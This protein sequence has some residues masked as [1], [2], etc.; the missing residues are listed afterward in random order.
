MK[1]ILSILTFF[2]VGI[3]FTSGQDDA[4]WIRPNKGQWD[5]K[6]LYKVDLQKGH[7]FVEKDKFTYALTDYKEVSHA[8]H[9]ENSDTDLVKSHTV[10]SHFV[11]S[12]W[13]GQKVELNPSPFYENYFLGD[14]STKWKSKVFAFQH[15][16]LLDFYPGID[17]ILQSFPDKL[18]YSFRVAP[19][20][21]PSLIQVFHEGADEVEVT[22]DEVKIHTRFG[23]I[24]ENELLVWE[25][26]ENGTKTRV[27]SKFIKKGDTVSFKLD[28]YN[29][30][31]TLI[32]DPSLT[33][34]TFTGSPVD[35]WGFTAA[36]DDEGNLYG[37]GIVFGTGYPTTV[38]AYDVSFNGGPSDSYQIDIGITKFSPDGTQLVYSTYIGG[39]NN[40]TPN[41]II[42]TA[43]GELY[44]LG[45]TGSSNFPITANAFQNIHQGGN[46]TT[47]IA[48]KF[49]GT[50]I[51][52]CK[53]SADGSQMLASTFL[54]GEGNDGLN[55][56]T[57]NYNY[58]DVFR[59]E[60]IIDN[61]GDVVFTSTTQ[62]QDFPIVNGGITSLG[63]NQDAIVVKMSPD[64]SDVIWSTFLGGSHD[65]AGFSVQIDSNDDI[66]ITGGTKSVDF[67]I[68]GGVNPTY[69]GG[70]SDGYVVKIDG[71][72]SAIISGTFIG[73][74]N[75]D[76]SFFVQLDVDNNV[77]VFG[78]SSGNIPISSG[79]YNNPN[80][81]QFIQQFSSDLSTLNWSTQ[82]GGGN[83]YV[84]ISPTAFLVSNCKEIYFSGWGGQINQSV[85]AVGSTSYGFPTTPDAYQ[86]TTNGNNFYIGVLSENATNLNYGTF[87][88]G[89]NSSYNHVDGGT[90]RFDK[91]GTIYHA[92]CG[93]CGGNPSGFTTTPGVW[94]ETN[95]SSNCNMAVWKFDLYKIN[96]VISTPE[97]TI[98]L[99]DSVFFNNLSANGSIYFWD[100]GDGSTSTDESPEHYYSQPGIYEVMLVVSEP[101]GCF[102]PDTTY[103]EIEILNFE[104]GN[105]FGPDRV[106][107][108]EEFQLLA[109]GGTIYEWEPA[110]LLND[111]NIADPIA[112]IDSTT[113]F[114]VLIS[115]GC[116]SDTIS[117]LVEV[118]EMNVDIIE[119]QEVCLNDTIQL[120]ASGGATYNWITDDNAVFIGNSNQANVTVIL[121]ENTDFTVE[122][123]SD[124]GC[125]MTVETSVTVYQDI[126]YSILEDT[127]FVC[128][129]D[130]VTIT[131]Q[132]DAKSYFWYS[133]ENISVNDSPTISLS[134]TNDNWYFVDL[135]NPCGTRVDSV[136]IQMVS[137]LSFAG[138]DTIVCRGEPVNLWATGGILYEWN[139]KKNVSSPFEAT[140]TAIPISP[141]TYTVTIH[142]E[143]GCID[144]SH[145]HINHFPDPYVFTGSDYYG[146]I[147]DE[148][149]LT[150][151]GSGNSGVF[152]WEPSDYLSCS[153]CKEPI[154]KP[155][156]STT[157]F[158]TYIDENGCKAT[159]FL[160]VYFETLL[161]VP[162]SFTPD[163]NE[164]NNEFKAVG[165]NISEFHMQIFNRWGELLFESYD[166]NIGWD[167]NYGN[168][169][170]K[171][172][173]YVWK[174]KYVDT[175]GVAGELVGHVNLLR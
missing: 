135:L 87:M 60:I 172:G 128:E 79:V 81:G 15:V 134:P 83:G 49:G 50:D 175:E 98:C 30:N 165:G 38:G 53:L 154:A 140:T 145:V 111:P 48:I 68:V 32:I 113:E 29:N 141:T 71:S 52:V 138:S 21:D 126:P 89:L 105:A 124:I 101:T 35:N 132:S 80:S 133:N 88:G 7:F 164:F 174:I 144:S 9:V 170:C 116:G 55:I 117:V 152:M 72:T 59:G 42:T 109:E 40:E 41:S 149:E 161:H 73:T 3:S 151:N 167:G 119:E 5:S 19:E 47:Q 20:A 84:E 94:S 166:I 76:Q 64:L 46:V 100:F 115:D 163:A 160:D 129:N 173:T 102:L 45:I 123:T 1:A 125:E 91:H 158:V 142:N 112:M 103:F 51:I 168:E 8:N 25:E 43:T 24:I 137:A 2:L 63:G 44:I 12:S 74:D 99:P 104:G 17:L 97:P 66:F 131:V 78:Q 54:G 61:D 16:E 26:N 13:Q 171:D 62:S 27:S 58:G 86:S 139:P 156:H 69:I 14:D 93:A 96:A 11:N 106:C 28:E 114:I 110:D 130:E 143:Y 162:N 157:Y 169:M 85:S 70:D 65:D 155:P 120:W 147:G 57:L 82:V 136:F 159:D 31:Q 127:I 37:G 146:F 10:H 121:S 67:P 39:N 34:S 122:I 90:S 108:G 77:Y 56:S 148:V 6:I 36:P 153:N 92:V 75:Y 107:R 23:P 118:P 18:K 95:N 4:V 33:F 22:D 150:A